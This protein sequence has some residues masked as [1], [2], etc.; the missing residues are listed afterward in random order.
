MGGT[1]RRDGG[2][3]VSDC[4]DLEIDAPAAMAAAVEAHRPYVAAQ[5][6]A[7]TVAVTVAAEVAIRVIKAPCPDG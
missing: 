5:T 6:L 2:L 7:T 3:H 1:A 4:V